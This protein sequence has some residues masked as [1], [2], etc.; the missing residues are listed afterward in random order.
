MTFLAPFHADK[1]QTVSVRLTAEQFEELR[2]ELIAEVNAL[3]DS[4]TFGKL[5][6]IQHKQY[7]TPEGA[8]TEQTI[9]VGTSPTIQIGEGA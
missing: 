3:L 7:A 6:I 9:H 8:T 4:N 5:Q 2:A 1:D